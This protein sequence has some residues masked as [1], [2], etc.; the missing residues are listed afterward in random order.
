MD[1]DGEHQDLRDS[2][3]RSI[4][5]YVHGR[6]ECCITMCMLKS[7]LRLSVVG[8]ARSEFFPESAACLVL[9]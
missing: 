9:L 8:L 2:G 4:I 3:H 1:E 5:P 6:D 7:R